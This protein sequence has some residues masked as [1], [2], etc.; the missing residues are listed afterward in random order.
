[1]G[2]EVRVKVRV[3]VALSGYRRRGCQLAGLDEAAGE[4][5]GA[6]MALM[7]CPECGES[8]STEARACPKCGAVGAPR[9]PWGA[10]VLGA[11]LCVGVAAWYWGTN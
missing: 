5:H 1:M 2:G 9:R 8:I 11:V 3:K 7:K 10:L 4:G 6:G